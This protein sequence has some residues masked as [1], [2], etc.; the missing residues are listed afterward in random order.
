MIFSRIRIKA[1]QICIFL[2]AISLLVMP[3][4]FGREEEEP[5]EQE[6]PLEYHSQTSL[7]LVLTRGNNKNFSFSFD[8]NQTLK[9]QEANIFELKGRFINSESNGEKKSEVYY[10]HLKY[11]RKIGKRAYLLSFFRHERNRLAGYN[12]RL[13]LSLGG[14]TAWIQNENIEFSS[15]VAFG[16]NNEKNTARLS[17]GENTNKASFISSIITNTVNYHVSDTAQ[18]SLQEV[19]FLNLEEK[20]DFR[21]N[22]YLSLTASINSHLALKSSIQVVY[23]HLPVE[24]Y[25]NT[26][27]YFLSSIV[28]TI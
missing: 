4:A 25:K 27:F 18:F 1:A 21:L 14:G 6:K 8:T 15:E 2:F 5:E 19:L 3:S 26:D 12:Y 24:G 7:S 11:D 10:S 9:I 13:A 20:K 22:S 17:G 23:E 28:F 16:W